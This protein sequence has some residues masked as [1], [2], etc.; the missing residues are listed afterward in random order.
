M[1]EDGVMGKLKYEEMNVEVNKSIG[2]IKKN[3]K[4]I[5]NLEKDKM[6]E[7]RL[8]MVKIKEERIEDV[9]GGRVIKSKKEV[10]GKIERK[11][12]IIN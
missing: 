3:L 4:R 11:K 1:K 12:K 7:K 8:V 5:E 10:V 6:K 9:E 2:K